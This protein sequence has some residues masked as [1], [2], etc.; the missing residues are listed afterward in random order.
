[1]RGGRAERCGTWLVWLDVI[2]GAADAYGRSVCRVHLVPALLTPSHPFPHPASTNP[3]PPPST[4]PPPPPIPVPVCVCLCLCLSRVLCLMRPS[5]T[6]SRRRWPHLRRH[7]SCW[8]TRGWCTTG[9][10]QQTLT[11]MQHHCPVLC[12]NEGVDSLTTLCVLGWCVGGLSAPSEHIADLLSVSHSVCCVL[13]CS[14]CQRHSSWS[15][16]QRL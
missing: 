5:R 13:C 3:L 4:P 15:W 16:Q 8:R 2:R 9:T 6:L 10:Q 7:A 1:M 11:L 14:V 12:L